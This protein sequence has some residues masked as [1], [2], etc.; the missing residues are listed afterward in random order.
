MQLR[1]STP[2]KRTG[3]NPSRQNDFAKQNSGGG[4]F[5]LIELLVVIAII[6]ILAAMLLPALSAAKTKAQ[7]IGCLNNTKQ[8]TL[9]WHLY[10]VDYNDYVPNN[11]GVNETETAINNGKLDNWVNNVMTWEPVRP[12]RMSATLI[13]PGWRMECSG[14]T[15]R[16]QS[17][18]TNAQPTII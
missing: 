5:T 1:P 2:I 6:A 9:A 11:Y 8:L 3:S 14:N 7:G 15:Q 12:F 13:M 4:G 16:V 17:V 18:L 10:T